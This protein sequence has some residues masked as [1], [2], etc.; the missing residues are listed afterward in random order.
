MRN[1]NERPLK[2]ESIHFFSLFLSMFSINILRRCCR[3]LG[4][5]GK[6]LLGNDVP[7]IAE[8]KSAVSEDR[9]AFVGFLR[10]VDLRASVLHRSIGLS[11]DTLMSM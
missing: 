3:E 9:R 4:T 7:G 10:F 6:P 1:S 8:T 11:S 2:I 5:Q